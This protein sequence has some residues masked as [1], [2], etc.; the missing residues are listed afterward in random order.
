M[1]PNS[2]VATID[3]ERL[4]VLLTREAE[5]DRWLRGSID[6]AFALARTYRAERMQILEEGLTKVDLLAA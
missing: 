2:L 5:F 1:T 4:P 6:E 3:H